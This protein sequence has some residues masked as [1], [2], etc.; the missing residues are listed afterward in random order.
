MHILMHKN[1]GYN[2]VL[3]D[4]VPI[5][6]SIEETTTEYGAKKLNVKTN[7]E[8][9][10]L[11]YSFD[12]GATWQKKPYKIFTKTTEAKILVTDIVGN[13]S[14]TQTRTI[15][16]NQT[17]ID[18]SL[19]N[20]G[21]IIGKLENGN[22]LII[23]GKGKM[24]NALWGIDTD[25][26]WENAGINK[27]NIKT[28]EIKEGITSIGD[29][30]FTG[31]TNLE[32]VILPNS[33][34]EIGEHAF[35]NCNKI[36]SLN[37][38]KGLEKIKLFAFYTTSKIDT[39]YINNNMKFLGEESLKIFNKIYYNSNNLLI[40]KYKKLTKSAFN[41]FKIDNLAPELSN[42]SITRNKMIV[43]ATDKGGTEEKIV[44]DC[45][46]I[47]LYSFDGGNTWQ[48]SNEYIGDI[49]NI[50]LVIMDRVGN[51]KEFPI[52]NRIEIKNGP[53]KTD[54][55][56]GQDFKKDGL[57]VN[58]IYT[59]GDIK[60][61]TDYTIIGGNDLKTS[62][63]ALTIRYEENGITKETTQGITVI[64]KIITEISIKENPKKMSYYKGEKID[65]NG[66]VLEVKYNDE[67][68][69]PVTENY[70]ANI[71]ILEN[72]GNQD[73]EITYE[74][75]KTILSVTVEERKLN[76]NLKE[77][78]EEKDG[79]ILFLNGINQ[80]TKVSELE[81]ETNGNIEIKK[82]EMKL[83]D[84]DLIST[85]CILKIT[86]ENETKEFTIII[87]GDL[88][89]D[90]LLDDRDLLKMARYGVGLDKNL[91]GAYL[92]AANVEKDSAFGDDMDLLKMA[93][94]LVGLDSI[95]N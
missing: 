16:I 57:K 51:E 6:T 38:P 82:G 76:I 24:K 48:E 27:E 68:I 39:I 41:N 56:E 28:I 64:P 37:I 17:L 86:M 67:S 22:K 4:S 66:L 10:E 78:T 13:K 79:E 43:T 87:I 52:L 42:I 34:I 94:I 21:S 59:N 11:S 90:G 92:R 60:E 73:I 29:C 71:E 47:D 35:H 61:I 40:T 18:L 69:V 9:E 84:E 12:D 23:Q 45:S 54:Y 5:I 32:T 50:R 14:E 31:C 55:V 20:D 83:N 49:N 95:S 53:N 65:L 3:I 46:G 91:N 2:Y 77:Y 75:K 72:I 63:E 19:N 89:G 30:I 93:R 7:M 88:T 25:K 85:G 33:L 81:I 44:D 1:T 62:V 58:A 36:S 74:S 8:S 80:N 70:S 26:I 15:N